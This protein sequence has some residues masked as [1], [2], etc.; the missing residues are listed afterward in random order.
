MKILP[1]GAELFHVD[2]RI[3][4][5]D[6]NAMSLGRLVQIIVGALNLVAEP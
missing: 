6:L 5:A 2:R 1:V 4:M 3:D